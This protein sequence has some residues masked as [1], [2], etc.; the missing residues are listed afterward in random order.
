M[1]VAEALFLIVWS[2]SE[3]ALLYLLRK[4]MYSI[5]MEDYREK[6]MCTFKLIRTES[7]HVQMVFLPATTSMI[8]RD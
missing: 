6:L 2:G 5:T 7:S 8:A 4:F 3:A 1:N